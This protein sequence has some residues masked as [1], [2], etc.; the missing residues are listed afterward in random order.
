MSLKFI[1]SLLFPLVICQPSM[2]VE[3]NYSSNTMGKFLHSL[4]GIWG[5][6]S[7]PVDLAQLSN[8]ESTK[9]LLSITNFV[10]APIVH[11]THPAVV[12]K[13]NP[14]VLKYK[15]N[16]WVLGWALDGKT[17]QSANCNQSSICSRAPLKTC[18]Y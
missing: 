15:D 10:N 16:N 3:T 7:V 13:P 1:L 17:V 5:S 11:L 4:F 8:F 9:C 12:Q 2:P 18:F 14:A 6:P